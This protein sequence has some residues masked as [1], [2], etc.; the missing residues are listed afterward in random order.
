MSQESATDRICTTVSRAYVQ[1]TSQR[2]I[3]N[4]LSRV[5]ERICPDTGIGA[6][7]WTDKQNGFDVM[8]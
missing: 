8:N 7:E 3:Y 6:K 4:D 5:E 2:Y 1:S